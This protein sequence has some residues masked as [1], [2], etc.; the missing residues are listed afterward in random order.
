MIV[1]LLIWFILLSF[2]F[3]AL[4]LAPFV[5]TFKKDLE[6]IN[7]LSELKDWDNFVEIWTWTWKVARYL[8]LKNPNTNVVWIELNIPLYLYAKSKSILFW[9]K[10]FKIKFWNAL[11]Y[12][13]S[14]TQVAYIFWVPETVSSKIKD[15]L[16]KELPSSAK[17]M[18]YVFEVKDW[19]WNTFFDKEKKDSNKI[20]I[21]IK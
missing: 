14:N 19:D 8:A 11:N 13:Y 5:P 10:N 18:S 4:S 16:Y 12:D 1:Y 7:R 17:Y 20:Y 3:T 9:P 2:T 15:K 21:C 6:R